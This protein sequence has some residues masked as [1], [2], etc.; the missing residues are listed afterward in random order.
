VEIV[1][2]RLTAIEA[3]PDVRLAED[4]AQDGRAL[5]GPLVL[6]LPETTVAI[7]R[8]WAGAS[9]ATG[10]LVLERRA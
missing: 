8:G 2:V 6:H 5:T 10:T 1:T 3:G 9:D 7:P 4:G